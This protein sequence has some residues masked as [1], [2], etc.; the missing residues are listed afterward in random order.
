MNNISNLIGYFFGWYGKGGDNDDSDEN[1]DNY[2]NEVPISQQLKQ[3]SYMDILQKNENFQID[4]KKNLFFL[5]VEKKD[6]EKSSTYSVD[7]LVKL[8]SSV[9]LKELARTAF[10]KEIEHGSLQNDACFV[11]TII[12]SDCQCLATK[13]KASSQS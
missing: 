12:S 5:I 2:N 10:R 13:N 8:Y 4:A 7:G 6:W 9:P 11:H 3:L 1:D